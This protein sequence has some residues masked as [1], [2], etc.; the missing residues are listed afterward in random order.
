MIEVVVAFRDAV[1]ATLMAWGGVDGETAHDGGAAKGPAA[2]PIPIE[3]KVDKKPAA[4]LYDESCPSR[5][6]TQI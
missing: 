5:K 3:K 4:F 2:K 1:M 6:A